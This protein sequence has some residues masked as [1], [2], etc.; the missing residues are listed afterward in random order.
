[1][2]TFHRGAPLISACFRQES[3]A[4]PYLIGQVRGFT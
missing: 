3:I 2:S 1:M 4:T